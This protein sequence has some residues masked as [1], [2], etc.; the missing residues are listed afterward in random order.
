MKSPTGHEGTERAVSA[1]REVARPVE[2]DDEFAP[3]RRGC[4]GTQTECRA[5]ATLWNPRCWRRTKIGRAADSSCRPPGRYRRRS[6]R[7]CRPAPA[8]P[9]PAPPAAVPPPP[10]TPRPP[11]PALGAGPAL[12][13]AGAP[14][15]PPPFVPATPPAPPRTRPR[16]SRPARRCRAS[17]AARP[18][19]HSPSGPKSRQRRRS[20]RRAPPAAAAPDCPPEPAV[21]PPSPPDPAAPAA[22]DCPFVDGAAH[23]PK[24]SKTAAANDREN[25]PHPRRAAAALRRNAKNPIRHTCLGGQVPPG[26]ENGPRPS[27]G[28][29]C[30]ADTEKT[31]RRD[32]TNR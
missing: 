1:V 12:A 22:P 16:A 10:A 18:G 31:A 6:R 2:V 4:R 32:G 8:R 17:G 30:C 14:P 26:A 20:R 5:R 3:A 13:G 24:P 25:A 7:R 28:P 15:A 27:S 21:R 9:A 11:D 29:Q 23:A 19:L